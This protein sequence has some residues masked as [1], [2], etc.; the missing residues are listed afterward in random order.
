MQWQW[1]G[2]FGHIFGT[3]VTSAVLIYPLAFQVDNYFRVRVFKVKGRSMHPCLNPYPNKCDDWVYVKDVERCEVCRGDVVTFIPPKDPSGHFIKRVIGLEGDTVVK[4]DGPRTSLVT[5]PGGHYW[6][7][8]DNKGLS[9]DSQQFGPIP[10]SLLQSK[11]YY[12]IWPPWRW[13][14]IFDDNPFE[15]KGAEE[16]Q[17]SH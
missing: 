6:V 7:E 5:V 14:K 11:A 15:C 16:S 2:Y 9:I 13:K 1:L 4:Q 8:G 10:R 12:I 17:K 3:A